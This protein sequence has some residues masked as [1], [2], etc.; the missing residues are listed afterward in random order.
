MAVA[1]HSMI[2]GQEQ[3]LF[4]IPSHQ[5]EM[6]FHHSPVGQY[7][8]RYYSLGGTP[9]PPPPDSV[10]SGYYPELDEDA[11]HSDEEIQKVIGNTLCVCVCVHILWLVVHVLVHVMMS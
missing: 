7:N 2:P 9:S 8:G 6:Q 5:H 1:V 4:N 3:Q 10:A 11:F